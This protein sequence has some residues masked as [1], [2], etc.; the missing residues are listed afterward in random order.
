[1]QAADI[2]IYR[3]VCTRFQC[4]AIFSRRSRV[5]ESLM[6]M[7]WTAVK[8]WWMAGGG[9]G[10]KE[11]NVVYLFALAIITWKNIKELFLACDATRHC[12]AS[13]TPCIYPYWCVLR[14]GIKL[15]TLSA[16]LFSLSNGDKSPCRRG[17]KA[18]SFLKI[19]YNFIIIFKYN[20]WM[21]FWEWFARA[22][23]RGD[24]RVSS[25]ALG[26]ARYLD[27]LKMSLNFSGSS[28]PAWKVET[29]RL[30]Y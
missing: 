1:M 23:P 24:C 11:W 20:M 9:D 27:Q 30:Q 28:Y 26:Q 10:G 13:F 21:L 3:R 5:R 2:C 18:I 6:L 22:E 29:I 14:Y 16:R 12:R 15:K 25:A 7:G 8:Q 17:C 19:E 4:C